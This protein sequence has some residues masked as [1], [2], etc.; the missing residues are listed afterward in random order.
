M[1]GLNF[2]GYYVT[3]YQQLID[4]HNYMGRDCG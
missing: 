1:F 4:M 3:A 2:I